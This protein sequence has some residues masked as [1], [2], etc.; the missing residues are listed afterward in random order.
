[1]LTLICYFAQHTTIVTQVENV[2]CKVHVLQVG[3]DNTSMKFI[4]CKYFWV[5]YLSWLWLD[6]ED[7][8]AAPF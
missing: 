8:A 5:V 1:M 2:N 6:E 7:A 3:F 4:Q